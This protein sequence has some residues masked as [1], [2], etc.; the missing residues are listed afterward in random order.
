M[1]KYSMDRIELDPRPLKSPIDR[2]H[3]YSFV[4]DLIPKKIEELRGSRPVK[5]LLVGG[6]IGVFA[7]QLRAKFK[8][9]INVYSTGLS[10]R[11]VKGIRRDIG[12]AAGFAIN[13]HLINISNKLHL[14]DLKWR[15]ILQ[16]SEFPEFDF[17]I[18]TVGEYFYAEYIRERYLRAVIA[19]LLPG[20]MASIFPVQWP[21]DPEYSPC[22][23]CI[24]VYW[25]KKSPSTIEIR[26]SYE[27]H[28]RALAG[29]DW[30]IQYNNNIFVPGNVLTIIK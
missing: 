20:G 14:H 2:L 29:V 13:G 7:E 5:I 28:R 3:T 24:V 22:D 17:I 16:L 21:A 27:L 11:L 26:E 9:Q 1:D 10:K 18:D 6:G 19:K 30:D 15:S 23:S 12:T 25:Q 8:D 4:G